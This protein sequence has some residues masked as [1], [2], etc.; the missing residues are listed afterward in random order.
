MANWVAHS[1]ID[2]IRS[3]S[4]LDAEHLPAG[5]TP[6]RPVSQPLAAQAAA[7]MAAICPGGAIAA[8]G[9]AVGVDFVHCVHCQRCRRPD[10]D[11]AWREDAQW[12][13]WRDAASNPL[14]HRFRRSV[15][16]RYLDA[17]ACGAC[18][19]EVRL[20]DAPPYNLHRY[21]IF[22][23]ATPRDADVLLVAGPV[24]EAMRLPLRKTYEAMP[25]PKRVVAMGVCAINGGVFG[26]SFASIGGAGDVV[27]VDLVIA[28]CPPPPLAIAHGLLLAAGQLQPGRGSDALE[29]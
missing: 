17:G 3:E 5:A 2:G 28:G 13:A 26:R 14:P 24:T 16:V 12:G 11:L 10:G 1:L 22:V 29:P 7:R 4:G 9:D 6:G 25:E 21:G 15:N 23:T 19:G 27:P 20:I 8:R 18:M